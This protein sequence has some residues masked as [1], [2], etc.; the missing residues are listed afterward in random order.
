MLQMQRCG[1]ALHTANHV[2]E[3][4]RGNCRASAQPRNQHT[5]GA[6]NAA[7]KGSAATANHQTRVGT[8]AVA[9][10][11]CRI[12]RIIVCG[13]NH[14]VRVAIRPV[15]I[16]THQGHALGTT[17][18]VHPLGVLRGIQGLALQAGTGVALLTA[19][20]FEAVR[21]G[22]DPI[23][24]HITEVI[25]AVHTCCAPSTRQPTIPGYPRLTLRPCW[26]RVARHNVRLPSPGQKG[27][28]GARRGTKKE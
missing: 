19:N 22:Q 23:V 12:G 27:F 16:R 7:A 4:Q 26:T 20:G 3:L 2:S 5:R 21:R 25:K 13:R 9:A 28:A 8:L 24:V 14:G 18:A 6:C 1:I 17:E 11:A 10:T 15:T